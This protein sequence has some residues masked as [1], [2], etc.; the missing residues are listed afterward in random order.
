MNINTCHAM[1]LNISNYW[2]LALWIVIMCYLLFIPASQIPGKAFLNIPN[3]DK[4]VHFG[5]FFILCL[6]LFRPVKQFTPNFYFWT[7]LLALV[8]AVS[9]EF[10]QEHITA[11][12]SS[13]AFDLLAN[14]AGLAF[15]AI[16][17][18][19]FIN[20]KKLEKLV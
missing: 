9:L 4:I 13:D 20:G 11:S 7:P 10:L 3:L 18:R 16:F 6:L 8:L 5:M 15:A 14:S 2:R 19:L 12:R 1:N 17:Y